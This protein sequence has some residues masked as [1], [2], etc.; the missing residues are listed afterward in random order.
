[1]GIPAS[2]LAQ[3]LR[4][5]RYV[6]AAPPSRG[7]ACPGPAAARPG[8]AAPI[9]EGEYRLVVPLEMPSGNVWERYNRWKR[10]DV[11]QAWVLLIS[12]EARKVNC[13][14]TFTPRKMR[15]SITSYRARLLDEVDNLRTGLKPV[16]DAL[17][18]A[19]VIWDDGPQWLEAGEIKQVVDRKNRRTE[20]VV[21]KV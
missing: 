13:P 11:K 10:R 5:Q 21:S 18:N 9:Y 4:K 12:V 1:M 3:I 15:V 17:R 2:K 19:G 16:L 7:R 6:A 14:T 20:I 8:A